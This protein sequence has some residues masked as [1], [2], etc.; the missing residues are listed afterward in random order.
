[1]SVH[2]KPDGR[3]FVAFRD[4][5]GNQHKKMFGRGPLA[6][7][8]AQSFDL[9]LKAERKIGNRPVPESHIYFGELAQKYLDERRAMGNVSDHYIYS[10][11]LLI[12]NHI[13][14][15]LGNR[16][17]DELTY[18]DDMMMVADHFKDRSQATKNRYFT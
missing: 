9:H 5:A 12:N 18:N 14:P 10:I 16:P 3:F 13:G 4:E 1:M 11:K 15:L 7:K 6:K 17:V 2:K 8:A